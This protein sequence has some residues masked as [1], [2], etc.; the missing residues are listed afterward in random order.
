MVAAPQYAT[1]LFR[2]MSGRTYAKDVYLSDTNNAL[3][4][5]DAGAGASATSATDIT[6]P[7]PV[8]LEDYS[9]VTGMTDTTK[10]QLVRDNVPTGDMLRYAIHL[11]TLANRPKLRIGIKQGTRLTMIQ[12]S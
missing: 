8:V 3:A 11:T 6:F 2:G 4:N 9:Q 5:F 1:M 12:K 7:E 10:V